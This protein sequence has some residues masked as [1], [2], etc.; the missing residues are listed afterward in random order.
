M[1]VFISHASED[2]AA[3]ARPLAQALRERRIDVWFDE[4]SLRPGDSLRASID[5][6]LASCDY[7]IVIL[8]DSFF[9]KGWPQRE[10]NGLFSRSVVSERRFLIPVRHDMTAEKLQKISPLLGDLISVDSSMG[11]S[12]IAKLILAIAVTDDR[13]LRQG[14]GIVSDFAPTHRFYNP[15]GELPRLGYRLVPGTYG[16]LVDQLRARELILA[17]G[18]PHASYECAGHVTSEGRMLEFERAWWIAPEYYAVEFHKLLD[19]FD[20]PLTDGEINK[21]LGR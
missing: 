1:K 14:G 5:H 17:Y 8:S 3:I 11:A 13:H 21:L 15:P 10:L 20:Q 7:G 2:K 12:E 4:Y 16:Q 6:G 9:A 19:G 18:S